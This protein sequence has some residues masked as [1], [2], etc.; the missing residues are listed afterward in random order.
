MFNYLNAIRCVITQ[1]IAWYYVNCDGVLDIVF[2]L[3]LE[4]RCVDLGARVV[5][6]TLALGCVWRRPFRISLFCL[7]LRF[8]H[9]GSTDCT[10]SRIT[11][12]AGDSSNWGLNPHFPHVLLVNQI[13]SLMSPSSWVLGL[14]SGHHRIALF[15]RP[16]EHWCCLQH[17]VSTSPKIQTTF[18][19]GLFE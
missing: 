5:G 6:L 1:L 10:V 13:A 8:Y 3:F 12:P 14:T 2:F 15:L 16:R 4:F 17:L 18:C 9:N 19:P 11:T 7:E